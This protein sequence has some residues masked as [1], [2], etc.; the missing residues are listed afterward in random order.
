MESALD[1]WVVSV[2]TKVWIKSYGSALVRIRW[3]FSDK[4]LWIRGLPI[5]R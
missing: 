5:N 3:K 1:N 4:A 2:D